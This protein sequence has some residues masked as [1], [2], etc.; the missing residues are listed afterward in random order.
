MQG[1][2]V[3][4]YMACVSSSCGPDVLVDQAANPIPAPDPA[5]R[6][7]DHVRRLVGPVLREALVRP[8]LVIVLDE[9]GQEIAEL[10]CTP[11][12]WEQE[13]LRLVVRR[14]RIPADELSQNPR[15]RRRRTVPKDQL[16]WLLRT[17]TPGARCSM[18]P[19]AADRQRLSQ[20]SAPL[21]PIPRLTDTAPGRDGS[22]RRSR[23]HRGSTSRSSPDVPGSTA[24][25]S[26]PHARLFSNS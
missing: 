25:G 4:R 13:P 19:P 9:L 12:G 7:G 6:H 3:S 22:R 18:P 14:V 23:P 17:R 8:S 10:P 11:A 26:G 2:Q 24:D 21:P 15:S 16:E 5:G 20:P 1:G